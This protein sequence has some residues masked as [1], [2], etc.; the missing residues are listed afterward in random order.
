MKLLIAEDDAFFRN[1]VKQVLS[2]EHELIFAE[3][4]DEAWAVLQRPDAPRFAILDWVMPGLSGPQVCRNVRANSRLSS[5]YLIL[6]TAKN[7]AA[8]IV[9]GLRAGADDYVTKPFNAE[10]LRM[11]VKL[12]K[13][14][15]DLHDAADLHAILAEQELELQTSPE[16]VAAWP[17]NHRP[18]GSEHLQRVE[19]CLIESF[20]V[21]VSS[22]SPLFH[23]DRPVPVQTSCFLENV[24][25]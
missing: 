3:N 6:F 10:E 12:G 5:M 21:S 18:A 16:H 14:T 9:A 1:I 7:S 13:L 19:D 25:A 15:L 4:G 20:P 11:C 23:A 17:F 22:P 2:P 8:D 24:H